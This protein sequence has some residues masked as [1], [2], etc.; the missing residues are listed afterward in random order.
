M[1]CDLNDCIVDEDLLERTHDYQNIFQ[2]AEMKNHGE[3]SD[4]PMGSVFTT[5]YMA[6]SMFGD[7]DIFA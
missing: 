3:I 2:Y 5:H 6:G 4:K 1:N 7:S